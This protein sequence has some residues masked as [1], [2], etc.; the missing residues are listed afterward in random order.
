MV[1]ISNDPATL[2]ARA[3]DEVRAALDVLT[4]ADVDPESAEAALDRVGERFSEMGDLAALEARVAP[5]E[6][7]AWRESLES[8]ARLHAVLTMTFARRKDALR[9]RL[10]LA[11]S[12]RRGSDWHDTDEGAGLRCNVRG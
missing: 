11:K 9:D 1:E 10:L 12:A 8:L 6:L 3:A 5:G 7:T 2:I 4:S